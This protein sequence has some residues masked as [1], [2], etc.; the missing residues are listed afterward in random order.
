MDASDLI[1]ALQNTLQGGGR[2]HMDASDLIKA[3]QNTL[4]GGGRPHMMTLPRWRI[5]DEDYWRLLHT[6]GRRL[7]L[8]VPSNLTGPDPAAQMI[9]ARADGLIGAVMTTIVAAGRGRS[10]PERGH[11]RIDR[12]MLDRVSTTTPATIEALASSEQF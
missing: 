1:K 10:G 5:E 12:T 3:L 4:Q 11:E 9:L 2:P 7:P 6:F 8:R